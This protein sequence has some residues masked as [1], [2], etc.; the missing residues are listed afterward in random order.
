VPW[1]SVRFLLVVF[2]ARAARKSTATIGC[3]TR[4]KS[5][6]ERSRGPRSDFCWWRLERGARK[7]TARIGCATKTE[8]RGRPE[9]RRYITKRTSGTRAETR[10]KMPH[11]TR[12]GATKVER[13]DEERSL[14]LRPAPAE[15][16]RGRKTA[17]GSLGE[18]GTSSARD[19]G[20]GQRAGGTKARKREHSQDGLY[21]QGKVKN[22]AE[23]WSSIRFLLMAAGARV[24]RKST[25]RIGCAT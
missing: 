8:E 12:C 24:A 25:A 11:E 7:S 3:A 2:R 18:L 9:G 6:T 21:H 20:Q 10:P 4:A 22:G 15:L 23:P 14:R 5:R 19:D 17:R 13:G 1:S 16:R